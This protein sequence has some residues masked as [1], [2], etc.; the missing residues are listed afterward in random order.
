MKTFKEFLKEDE[1]VNNTFKI[2]H[3][4]KRWSF[5]PSE[6]QASEKNRYEAGVGIYF[7]NYYDTA[8]KY[9]KGGRVIHLVEI[10][11]NF[12]N[13]DDVSVEVN[14]FVKD[15]QNI[16][17]LKQKEKII[18]DIRNYADSRNKTSVPLSVLNNLVVNYEVGSGQVGVK[19]A[20]YFVTKGADATME[21][22][23]S[24]E[25]WLV[26]F[27]PKIIKSVKVIDQSKVKTSDFLISSE[28]LKKKYQS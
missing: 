20:N 9:S 15:I 18:K 8:L 16:S 10:D 13:I 23:G 11:K 5:I 28:F 4:G 25:F 7:T 27:N 12:K 6:I 14:E 22:K 1:E 26:V 19:I 2:Y 17:G 3:G 21:Q 24:E